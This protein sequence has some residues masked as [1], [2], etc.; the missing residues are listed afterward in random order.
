MDRNAILSSLMT[1]YKNYSTSDARTTVEKVLKHSGRD[2]EII[3]R[4]D[5]KR[6]VAIFRFLSG[7]AVLP[8]NAEKPSELEQTLEVL[9]FV[10]QGDSHSIKE[11]RYDRMFELSDQLIDWATDTDAYSINSDLYTLSIESV[12]DTREREGYFSATLNFTIIIKIQ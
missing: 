4:A 10:E 9:L 2:D 1:S 6:E 8:I 11:A 7:T 3:A 12:G 5:I